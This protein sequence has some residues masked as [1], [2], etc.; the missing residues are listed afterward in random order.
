MIDVF[1]WTG[2]SLWDSWLAIIMSL[3]F[4]FYLFEDIEFSG[5]E[6]LIFGSLISATDPVSTLSVF[7]AVAA[8]PMLT[9]LM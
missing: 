7:S 8:E 1:H 5:M 3:L 6:C 2:C 4:R 9:M